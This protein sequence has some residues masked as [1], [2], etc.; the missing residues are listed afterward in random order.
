VVLGSSSLEIQ[1][2]LSDSLTGRFQL[3]PAYHWNFEETAKFKK[4]SFDEYLKYGGYPGSYGFINKSDWYD[5]IKN[6]IINTVVEKDILQYQHIKN[7]SL[8]RQAFELLIS[9]PAQEISYTKLLGQIQDKGNVDLIKGYIKLYEGAFLIKT[10]EKF[11]ANKIK[12]KLSSPKILPLA[13]CLYQLSI[14]GD[15]SGAEKGRVFEAL[16]G[17]QLV[18]TGM[19]LYYWRVGNDEVDFILKNGRHIFAIEVKSGRRDSKK[20]LEKFKTLFPSSKRV[21]I[22]Y[23]DYFTFE[24]DPYL[25]L[26]QKGF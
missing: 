16:V 22:S 6:S 2:G 3:T 17:A 14:N 13:P 7:P 9:Y 8:F 15:Y 10:L 12:I 23:E 26:E 25:Y 18:R 1:K 20:A 4:I 21:F 19:D 24:K 11:S 5:Y